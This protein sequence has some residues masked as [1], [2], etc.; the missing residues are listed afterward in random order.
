MLKIHS[1]MLL[2]SSLFLL[3][4]SAAS[5]NELLPSRAISGISD[6]EYAWHNSVMEEFFRHSNEKY[7]QK[8]LVAGYLDACG[9]KKIAS[10]LAQLDREGD[11]E[12]LYQSVDYMIS[13]NQA[14]IIATTVQSIFDYKK[15]GFSEGLSAAFDINPAMKEGMCAGVLEVARDQG[16]L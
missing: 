9:Y 7:G 1:R 15:Q 10:N 5:A 6:E 11:A 2:M 16:L 4:F 13:P 14:S 3:G 12:A 8:Y